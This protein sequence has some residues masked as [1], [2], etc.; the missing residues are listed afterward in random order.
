MIRHSYGGIKIQNTNEYQQD[1]K[2]T[3]E[4]QQKNLTSR[5]RGYEE[6]SSYVKKSYFKDASNPSSVYQDGNGET[7]RE[8]L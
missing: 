4:T 3:D 7:N 5:N 6:G 1:F 8:L 2:S